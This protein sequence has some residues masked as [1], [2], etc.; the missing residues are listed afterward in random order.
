MHHCPVQAVLFTSLLLAALPARAEPEPIPADSRAVRLLFT[1]LSDEG[2]YG[3]R[4]RRG[5]AL[6]FPAAS[7]QA[8][9][10]EIS[11]HE[12][13]DSHCGGDPQTAPALDHFR[14]HPDTGLILW[15]DVVSGDFVSFESIC[16]VRHCAKSRPPEPFIQ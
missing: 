7:T 15:L 16:R 3:D 5:C 13:H 9:W 1:R 10:L 6:F 14:L 11:V 8:G 4:L 2:L 12:K